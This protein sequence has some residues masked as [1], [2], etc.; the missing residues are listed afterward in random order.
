MGMMGSIGTCDWCGK[1]LR[2]HTN[3]KGGT[4]IVREGHGD[5][6]SNK[7][8]KT[9]KKSQ[10]VEREFREKERNQSSGKNIEI[11]EEFVGCLRPIMAYGLIGIGIWFFTMDD[12]S[13]S[14][15]FMPDRVLGGIICIGFGLL[16]AKSKPHNNT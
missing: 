14:T 10:I 13:N 8:S 15:G 6:C 7:C 1:Q 12:N 4:T 3:G 2:T 16:I 9:C 5:F 11:S